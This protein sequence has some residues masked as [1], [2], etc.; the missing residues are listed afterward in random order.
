[1]Q[2]QTGQLVGTLPYMS[3][4]QAGG[5]AD[6]ID[7]RA[8]RLF[9]PGVLALSNCLSARTCRM[10]VLEAGRSPEAGKADHICET[11]TDATE[12]TSNRGFRGDVET[13]LSP[14]HWRRKRSAA[15]TGQRRRAWRRE[16][17]RAFPELTGR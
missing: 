17:S 16:Q 5:D 4:E 10:Q 3:P 13:I 1:M 6:Q 12:Q 15:S 14:K 11:G 8:R 2:T 7:T 9:A